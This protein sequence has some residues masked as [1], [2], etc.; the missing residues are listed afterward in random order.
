MPWCPKCKMEYKDGVKVCSDCGCE[1]TEEE[2]ETKPLTFGTREE[3]EELAA[4]LKYSHIDGAFVSED[5]E[6][7]VYELLVPVNQENQA[8]KLALIFK[9]QKAK[10]AVQEESLKTPIAP[11]ALYENSAE[12][13]EDNK[14]SAYTLLL[15]GVVGMIVIALGITGVLP[16]HL[17][18]T[19]K[20]MTYGIMSV[21]FLLF[22]VMG[23]ISMK[24]YRIFA[25][26]A[27]S[28]NSLRDTM[29]KWCL[30]TL[31]PD[32][33]DAELFTDKDSVSEEEKYFKRT[34]LV[35]EKISQKFMNLDAAFLDH[36]VDEIYADIFEDA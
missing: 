3:M 28:E 12:K 24:S 4:F 14:S 26:K 2:Y 34:V 27:E 6:D 21:L 36:F 7:G 9:Q 30:E 8:G 15:V 35:K 16:I 22:I 10:E 25:K 5:E 31:L 17:S 29:E 23:V 13:A 20:Y 32:E 19:S 33:L 18:G 11:A 1:L